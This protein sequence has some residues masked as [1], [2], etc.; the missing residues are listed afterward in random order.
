[1]GTNAIRTALAVSALVAAGVVSAA[2]ASSES[3]V[4]LASVALPKSVLG[5]TARSLPVARDSGVNSNAE[6]ASESSSD[7]TAA[8]LKGLGRIT[9]YLLDYGNPFDGAAG[10]RQVQTEVELYG[11]AA[12][13]RK[14]LE[15]W[16]RD[17]L[18][19]DEL[20]A[21]GLTFSLKRLRPSGLPGPH[22]VYA[23]SVSIK[24]L[25]PLYGVDA[26]LQQGQ[27]LLDV[28]VAAGSTAAAAKLVPTIARK[29]NQRMRLALAGRLPAT[30]VK[31]PPPLNAGP[32]P[33]GP[34]PASLVLKPAD[35]GAST[36]VVHKGYSKPKDSLDDN[37]MSVY[38]VAMTS[39]GSYRFV[40][41][42]V[43][44]GGNG[45]E[46]QYFGAIAVS[47]VAATFGK[48]AQV[49][50]VDLS[51]VGDN[52]RGDLLKITVN[53]KTASEAILVLTHGAYL[54]FVVAANSSPITSADARSLARLM[55]TRLDAGFG[56]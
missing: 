3:H 15:F 44:V 4:D 25:Q 43:L 11:S 31:V 24:G 55:A 39:T 53:G 45:L 29:L 34:E 54:D 33:H 50:P 42:E 56:G 10:V 23:T 13:A 28:S 48:K 49:T 27:Y 37:A 6:A 51:G 41:Q 26:E 47:A 46:A 14:G 40:T 5:A 18:N 52:A 17:E 9:G 38:D 32:P 1:M 7:V 36:T 16:R 2:S 20:K 12:Q 35:I 30:H 22:W 19:N 21:L 8:K